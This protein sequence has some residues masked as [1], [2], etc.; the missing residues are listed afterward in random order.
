MQSRIPEAVFAVGE[1]DAS[2]LNLQDGQKITES[3]GNQH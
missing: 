3:R 2:R 1:Q